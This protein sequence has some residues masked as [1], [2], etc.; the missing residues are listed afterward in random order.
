MKNYLYYSENDFI[1][2]PDFQSWV[3]NPTVESEVFWNKFLLDNPN[4][5]PEIERARI[6]LNAVVFH[7]NL[8][9]SEKEAM[10]QGVRSAIQK[11]KEGKLVFMKKA[12][13]FSYKKI[14]YA[15]A[16]ILIAGAVLAFLYYFTGKKQEQ[17]V[18]TQYGEIK[19]IML[20]DN[21]LV[22]LNA[23]SNIKYVQKWDG[24]GEREVWIDGEAFFSVK[25]TGNNQRFI[26]HTNELDIEVLGTEFNVMRREEKLKVSLN[27]GKIKL[28]MRDSSNALYMMPGE[29]L[30]VASTFVKKSS[31]KVE[32]LSGWKENK[33]VFDDTP[34]S[35]IIVQ[36]KYIYGWEFPNVEPDLLKEKLTGDLET[37][38]EQMVINTLEK[39]FHIKINKEGNSINISRL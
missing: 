6:L 30:E 3:K 2:D 29:I 14:A 8:L 31:G 22:T 5:R 7:E 20:P 19:K 27:S 37:K 12:G 34:L 16:A 23:N 21:S 17:L 28:Q 9:P 26:V 33:L 13:T 1:M 15:S 11:E 24:E 10:W 4:K 36:L 32:E 39:A 18:T 25:H 38:D 35:E